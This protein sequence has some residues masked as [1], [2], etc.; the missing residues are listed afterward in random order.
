MKWPGRSGRSDLADVDADS[1]HI[2]GNPM[3][4][5]SSA[6]LSDGSSRVNRR[7]QK[8]W[9]RGSETVAELI[10]RRAENSGGIFR[11]ASGDDRA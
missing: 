11:Q 5:A 4:A 6:K 1:R 7:E 9:R 3:P 10:L 8:A 2:G